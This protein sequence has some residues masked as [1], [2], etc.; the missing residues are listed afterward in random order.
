M[1][2]QE[3]VSRYP[4]NS[5]VAVLLLTQLLEA[6]CHMVFYEVAHR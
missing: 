6:V 1:S 4:P 5:K 3:Y 2:L